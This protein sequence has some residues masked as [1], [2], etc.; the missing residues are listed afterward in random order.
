MLIFGLLTIR[1]IHQG[2]MRVAVSTNFQLNQKK[3]DRQLIQMLILQSFVFGSTTTSFSIINLYDSITSS[4]IVKNNLQKAQDT[5]LEFVAS[6]VAI[7]GPCL[8][9][10]LFTLSSNLFRR[11]LINLFCRQQPVQRHIP[12]EGS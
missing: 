9:F 7:A 12:A 3:I 10:Y 4:L 6:W 11:E 5:Y 8:S 2:K 1:L